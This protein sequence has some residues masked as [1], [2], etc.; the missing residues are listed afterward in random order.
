MHNVYFKNKST[1]DF[2]LVTKSIGRRKRAQEKVERESIPYRNGDLVTHTGF[3]ENYIRQM[4]F[5]SVEPLELKDIY[6][7]LDGYGKMRTDLDKNGFFLA[8]VD[9]LIEN[10]S[11]GPVIDTLTIDFNVE[12]FFYLNSGDDLL[13]FTSK[14]TLLNVGTVESEPLITIYGSGNIRLNVNSQ[15]VDL[16]NVSGSITMDTKNKVCYRDTL[17]MGRNMVG[18]FII[19]NKGKNTINWTGNVTKIEILPRW[20]ER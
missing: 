9:N 16:K 18:E 10:D 12:P 5:S 14:P 3:Y 17:N 20:C 19:F 15:F 7:W 13:T 2:N 8:S 11:D 1:H 6:E 4:E